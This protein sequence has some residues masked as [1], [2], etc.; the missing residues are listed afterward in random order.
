[1]LKPVTEQERL[2]YTIQVQA[3]KAANELLYEFLIT[4]KYDGFVDIWPITEWDTR[5]KKVVLDVKSAKVSNKNQSLSHPSA[6]RYHI[7]QSK[8]GVKQLA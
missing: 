8:G 2:A 6:I 3:E 4:E 1:M 7:S 5:K